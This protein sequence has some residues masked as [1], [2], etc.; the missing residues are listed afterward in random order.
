VPTP[1]SAPK[2]PTT[3]IHH[4]DTRIDDWYWLRERA[5]PEV[6]A[7]LEAE[8]A[9]TDAELAHLEALRE[10]LFEEI[11]SRI[12]ETDLSPPARKDGY[13]YY[14][15]TVEG[16][17]YAI[18][19]RTEGAV[20]G[21]EQILLDENA[22]AEGH[23]YFALGGFAVSPSHRLLAYSTDTE[24]DEVYTVRVR[25]L[26]T[27]GDLS[28][29]IPG[30]SYGLVWADDEEHL[31]YVTVNEAMRPWRL[32]RH[33]LG[34]P[35]EEDVLVHQEDDDAFYLGVSR[36]KSERFIFL[37]L[38]SKITSEV[39]VLPADRPTDHFTVIAPRRHGVEYQVDHHGEHFLILTNEG[40]APNF[41]LM[42]APVSG[43][44]PSQWRDLVPHRADVRLED[45]D[46]FDRHLVLVERADALVSL[47]VAPIIGE[48]T[49]LGTATLIEQPEPVYATGLGTNLEMATSTLRFGY[50]SLVT[51]RSVIDY[52]MDTGERVLVKQEPVLGGYDPSRYETRRLWATAPDRTRVPISLLMRRD[53]P[54]DGTPPALLYGYG[55]YEISIDPTFSSLRL[56]LV[57]RG[58]VF[59]IA[60][61]RGGGEMGRHWYED[62][63]LLRKK[64]TFTDFI[65]CAEHIVEQGVTAADRLVVRGGS[66]GGLLM[67]AVA[68]LR[69]DLFRA[70]VAE[71]PF[72][73]CLTT[74][75]DETL[76]LTVM[77]WEEWGNPVAD[78]EVYA[79]MKSYSPYDNVEAK[80]YPAMLVRAGLNDPR[81]SYWEPAKWVAKLRD[82]KTD[83]NRLVLRTDM[84]AGH[85]GPSGRYDAWKDEAFVQAFVLDVVGIT[86]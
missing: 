11:R 27:G 61:V 41:R 55:S 17:Q 83:G 1:P 25:D 60:H 47:R 49:A 26:T 76:P 43:P 69:P 38:E 16:L 67:G 66:A 31:F 3:L 79:T 28:D 65:A 33:R 45:V 19:C 35:P 40:D 51:P 18:H 63:K 14:S 22:L 6:T 20:D 4:G 68:N 82:R 36:S 72:V 23:G 52:D 50:T 81:V 32:H 42:V 78:P 74:I 39:H 75:L 34:A 70:V 73:D 10:R 46:V 53:R 29:E 71:V 5:N 86:E 12:Q 57:D 30:T 64:N 84:G 8:N 54:A 85:M 7:H 37:H 24:G 44:G 58:F 9:Y 15:R 21:P 59:A 48:V 77:E 62:G 80:D 2:R 13:W 56:S